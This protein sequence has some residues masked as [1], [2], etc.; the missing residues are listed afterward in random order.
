MKFPMK[1]MTATQ[2]N[3]YHHEAVFRPANVSRGPLNRFPEFKPENPLP[4]PPPKKSSEPQLEKQEV[5]KPNRYELTR[6][7]PS[8]T[9][10]KVNLRRSLK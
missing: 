9:L 2:Y 1:K 8:I 10:N 6:P 5:F 7:T 3:V 4:K